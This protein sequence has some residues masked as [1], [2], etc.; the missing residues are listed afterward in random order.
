MKAVSVDLAFA[1]DPQ[2]LF[3]LLAG[4]KGGA[5]QKIWLPDTMRYLEVWSPKLGIPPFTF[6]VTE[7]DLDEDVDRV[8]GFTSGPI[9]SNNFVAAIRLLK[10]AL[11]QGMV[12]LFATSDKQKIGMEALQVDKVF[13][14]FYSVTLPS[15]S[16]WHYNPDL[17]G[18]TLEALI[19]LQLTDGVVP[20]FGDTLF[21]DYVKSKPSGIRFYGSEPDVSD[22][23]KSLVS[24]PEPASFQEMKFYLENNAIVEGIAAK[25]IAGQLRRTR[26]S[27]L[28]II[29]TKAIGTTLIDTIFGVPIATGA[30]TAF[31]LISRWIKKK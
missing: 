5:H 26:E 28:A 8:F 27:E 2:K 10:F 17:G 19:G 21:V 20:Y 3:C 30:V 22:G 16:T 15:G 25:M 12:E 23:P 29:G 14:D 24:A 9:K 7:E 18:Q 31:D 11:D 1:L 13:P 4:L 6:R